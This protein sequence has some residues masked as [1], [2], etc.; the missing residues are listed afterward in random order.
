MAAQSGTSI[1]LYT[2]AEDAIVRENYRS[3]GAKALGA[4]INRSKNS[5]IGR[6][7]RL[8][9]AMSQKEIE[10]IRRFNNL[11]QSRKPAVAR[12]YLMVERPIGFADKKSRVRL[13]PQ[14]LPEETVAPLDGVGVK[15]WDL[16]STHCRWVMGDS[17]EM[18]FCGHQKHKGSH[19][20]EA[21]FQKSVVKK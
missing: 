7:H 16:E 9:V 1:N 10:E 15:I 17:K 4:L 2:E 8:G 19:Y 21:H 13:L 3:M 12:D 5:V 11:Q 14:K 6:A 20:C 18:T